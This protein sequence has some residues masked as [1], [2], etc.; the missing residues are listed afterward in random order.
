MMMMMVRFAPSVG[1]SADQ[2]LIEKRARMRRRLMREARQERVSQ[3]K[4]REWDVF[5]TRMGHENR[6]FLD[7][8]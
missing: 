2:E 8:E 5:V 3:E 4:E 1:K 6:N 7:L